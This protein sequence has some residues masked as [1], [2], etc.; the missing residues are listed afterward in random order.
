MVWQDRPRVQAGPCR[1]GVQALDDRELVS[2]GPACDEPAR[3]DAGLKRLARV[4]AIGALVMMGAGGCSS[5][6]PGTFDGV[7]TDIATSRK[8]VTLQPVPVEARWSVTT[9]G[10]DA[11]LGPTDTILWALVRYSDADFAA[12]S[13]ALKAEGALPAGTMGALP[14]WVLAD[15]DLTL[16]RHGSDGVFKE[17]VSAGRPFASSLYANGFALTLPDHRVLIHFSSQ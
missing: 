11:V 3:V 14:A 16:V 4:F 9:I 6:K 17:P 2:S 15:V 7:Q 13:Q 12:I 8:F 5:S 1:C 10:T